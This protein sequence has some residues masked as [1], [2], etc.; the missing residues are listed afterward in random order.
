MNSPKRNK[1]RRKTI[2]FKQPQRFDEDDDYFE[3]ALNNAA[4][5][6]RLMSYKQSTFSAMQL[7]P[8]SK[9]SLDSS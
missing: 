5:R 6:K 4:Q 9:L 7:K 2:H 8:C 1:Q 3:Q